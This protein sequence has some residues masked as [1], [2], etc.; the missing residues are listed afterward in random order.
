MTER[1]PQMTLVPEAIEI[2]RRGEIKS[3]KVNVRDRS[4]FDARN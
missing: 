1:P 4:E 3:V 2:F